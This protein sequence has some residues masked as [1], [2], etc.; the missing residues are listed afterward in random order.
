MSVF[1][2]GTAQT[3]DNSQVEQ[4]A[5]ETQDSFVKKL[6]EARGE[7]WSDPEVI[8]K[9]KLESDRYITDLERQ[10]SELRE[11]LAKNKAAEELLAKVTGQGETVSQSQSK[12][13]NN[14]ED[15]STDANTT[16]EVDINDLVEKALAQREANQKVQSNL[17][18]VNQ[19]L[20]ETFGTDAKDVVS[21]KATDL[22]LS[23]ERMQ[24]IA[25]E[26]PDAFM[27]L[28]GQPKREGGFA[29]ES[30]VNTINTKPN[31]GEKNWNYF[32]DLRRTNPNKY[33][34]PS[35]QNE[36]AQAR[37]ALGDRFYN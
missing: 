27:A 33:Y 16:S 4:K 22:G 17:Q 24:E 10:L 5:V 1:E 32:Q 7:Q 30:T 12:P 9:G 3:Q 29:K 2:D 13:K 14:N 15:G 28:L 34:T 25:K 8:A 26:S 6:V 20:E 21:Q 35:V 19:A 36:L 37:Q 23:M 31:S 11:D 18:R